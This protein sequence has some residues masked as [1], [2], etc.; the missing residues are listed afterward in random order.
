MA[1]PRCLTSAALVSAG[2]VY[3]GVFALPAG[4]RERLVQRDGDA[5]V[6]A[7]EADRAPATREVDRRRANDDDWF[8]APV[9][10][11]GY[12]AGPYDF[13]SA[14]IHDAVVA[15]AKAAAARAMFRRAESAL[16]GAVRRAK[17]SFETSA[18]LR[19][20]Q[21]A[22]Q[23]AYENY[24]AARREALRDVLASSKYQAMQ[25]L[26]EN[27]G[28]QIVDRRETVNDAYDRTYDRAARLKLILSS[29]AAE[30]AEREGLVAIAELKMRVGSD[31]RALEREALVNNER[32]RKAQ[33][34]LAA[35]SAKVTAL[36]TDFDRN[37]REDAG[38]AKARQALEDARVARL[39]SETYFRGADLAAGEALDFA[40][41]THRYDYYRYNRHDDYLPYASYYGY[42]RRSG[43]S[44]VG[45]KIRIM[46]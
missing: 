42:P 12:A 33:E 17:Q 44:Y 24:E 11:E 40:Y 35:A 1:F 32:V 7:D 10:D 8:R 31:A 5:E 25:E 4:A 45:G 34:D 23:R 9:R 20:A 19:E 27:L 41:F 30:A 21:A 14:E 3:L 16:S 29:P 26:R 13:P 22:E 28:R 46:P 36:R 39:V 18:E 15:N 6:F 2:F 43:Y 38:I 37:V